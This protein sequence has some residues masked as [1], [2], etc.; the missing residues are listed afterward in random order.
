MCLILPCHV[1]SLMLSFYD[2]IVNHAVLEELLMQ[3]NKKLPEP[4]LLDSQANLFIKITIIKFH[5]WIKKSCIITEATLISSNNLKIF[6][7]SSIVLY[8]VSVFLM[9]PVSTGLQGLSIC[10][11]RPYDDATRHVCHKHPLQVRISFQMFD[12]DFESKDFLKLYTLAI[13]RLLL[14]QSCLLGI[15][16]MY[17]VVNTSK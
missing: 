5:T 7:Q 13:I 4:D 12:E 15:F 16:L 3:G 1:H 6:R 10:L 8:T 2:G 9:N 14:F 11:N 17:A